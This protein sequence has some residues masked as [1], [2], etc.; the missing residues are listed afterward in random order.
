MAAAISNEMARTRFRL[1][2]LENVL[3]FNH[4]SGRQMESKIFT[5]GI[6][7]GRRRRSGS[8]RSRKS[9]AS[10]GGANQ[11]K[12][13][14]LSSSKKSVKKEDRSLVPASP[15][16]SS[17][18]SNGQRLPVIFGKHP[19]VFLLNYEDFKAARV[20]CSDISGCYL[21]GSFAQEMARIRTEP[22]MKERQ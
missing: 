2:E 19:F 6:I 12:K 9:Q 17:R 8:K 14:A 7:S 16:R 20:K 10:G 21:G 15:K 3:R 5:G 22:I 18:N 11:K 1:D 13:A 4:M